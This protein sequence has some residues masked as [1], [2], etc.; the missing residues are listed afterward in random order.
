MYLFVHSIAKWFA[1]GLPAPAQSVCFVE[2]V[3]FA[4]DIAARIPLDIRTNGQF[5]ERNAS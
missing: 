5:G 4:F 2:G 1:R 3:L